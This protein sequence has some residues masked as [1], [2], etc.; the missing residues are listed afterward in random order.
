[1]NERL[2]REEIVWLLYRACQLYA[3]ACGSDAPDWI[4][5]IAN[6]NPKFLE[7]AIEIVRDDDAYEQTG[8]V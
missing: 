8:E 3:E 4:H 5:I 1:M 2:S 7:D 6:A